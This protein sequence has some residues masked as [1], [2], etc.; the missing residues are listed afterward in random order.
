ME[1]GMDIVKMTGLSR[2]AVKNIRRG[3]RR[4]SMRVL[5]VKEPNESNL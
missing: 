4:V 2:L 5:V 3:K 1:Q